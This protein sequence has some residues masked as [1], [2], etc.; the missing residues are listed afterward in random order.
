[1]LD[2]RLSCLKLKRPH[3][4]SYNVLHIFNAGSAR[5][6]ELGI[7]LLN[8]CEETDVHYPTPPHRQE[9]L[10]RAFSV[11]WSTTEEHNFCALSLSILVEHAMDEMHMIY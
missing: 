1:M 11:D 2:N 10:K 6:D 4:E 8:Q 5:R 9:I 7:W 3:G